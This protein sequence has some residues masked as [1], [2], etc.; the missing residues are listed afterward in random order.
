MKTRKI[1]HACR[2]NTPAPSHGMLLTFRCKL[3]LFLGGNGLIKKKWPDSHI[4]RLQILQPG[5]LVQCWAIG[6]SQNFSIQP[7]P[8]W[9]LDR[10]CRSD[11]F[12]TPLFARFFLTFRSLFPKKDL[13]NQ[14][15][16][17]GKVKVLY[18][19]FWYF[20]G[21]QKNRSE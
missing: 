12:T 19:F 21:R 16:Y 18:S 10:S 3:W 20:F 8:G 2:A 13:M 9:K 4:R 17:V 7:G 14:I 11:L 15:R 6:I 1:N 5:K